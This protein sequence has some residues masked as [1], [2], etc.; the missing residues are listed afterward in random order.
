MNIKAGDLIRKKYPY[1]R[2]VNDYE[3]IGYHRTEEGWSGGCKSHIE[4]GV[5]VYDGHCLQE[6]FYSCDA[7][8]EIEYEVLAVVDMPRKYQQRVIY[9]VTMIEPEGNERRSSKT[10]T[11][12]MSKFLEW[13]TAW[14]SSYPHEY[15]VE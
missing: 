14:H 9:R 6:T 12:T 1:I 15:E 2:W 13:A 8:G 5:A 11:V 10:H 3:S 7:E 4:D